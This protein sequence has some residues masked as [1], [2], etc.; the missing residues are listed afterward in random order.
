MGSVCT[1]STP[2][3]KLNLIKRNFVTA[4]KSAGERNTD[5]IAN[6]SGRDVIQSPCPFALVCGSDADTVAHFR[7]GSNA[8]VWC[9][10][11]TRQG[12]ETAQA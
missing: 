6:S 9:N 10:G 12:G 1:Y 5:S 7:S 4:K 2:K 8:S 11:R 3:S